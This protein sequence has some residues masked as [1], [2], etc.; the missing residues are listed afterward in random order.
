MLMSALHSLPSAAAASAK[1]VSISPAPA[2]GGADVSFASVLSAQL[3]LSNSPQVAA[4]ILGTD[5]DAGDD[6]ALLHNPSDPAELDASAG[7]PG[8]PIALPVLPSLIAAANGENAQRERSLPADDRSIATKLQAGDQRLLDTAAEALPPIVTADASEAASFAA[9]L[10]SLP[11]D[12]Q[13]TLKHDH[14]ARSDTSAAPAVPVSAAT[15]EARA[16]TAHR[17]SSVSTSVSVPVQDSRW[18]QAFSERVVWVAGQHVQAAEIHVE[19][20]QLGPI[21]IR[22]SITNDQANLLFTAPHAVARDAIQMSLPRLQEML[23]ESGLSLGNVSVGAH[24]PGNQQG[25]YRDRS[26]G[27]TAEAGGAAIDSSSKPMVS[28]LTR[29]LGMVDLFA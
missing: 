18:S 12:E 21:E 4:L 2:E 20:P 28:A 6:K 17:A 3:G 15:P 23:F 14:A 22:V 10:Q 25:P 19:P 29:G 8:V 7:G 1:A 26:D 5:A 13:Q 9:T 16:D 27:A 11:G 24:T